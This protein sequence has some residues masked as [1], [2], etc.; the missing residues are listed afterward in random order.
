M[1][2]NAVIFDDTSNHEDPN[3]HDDPA[4]HNDPANLDDFANHDDSANNLFLFIISEYLYSRN[5]HNNIYN[6]LSILNRE[7]V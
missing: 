4:N 5:I 1:H 7:S 2:E 6:K 3:D